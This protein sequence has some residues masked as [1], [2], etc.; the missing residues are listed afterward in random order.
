M[1]ILHVCHLDGSEHRLEFETGLSVREVL[2]G[3][4]YRV[5]A[6]CGGTG[7]C[8]ACQVRWLAGEA[9]PPGLAEYQKLTP[10]ERAAGER[11]ACQLRPRG[12]VRILLDHPAPPSRW[13]SIDPADLRPAPGTRPELSQHVY[14]VAV[15]LGTIH[16]RVALW[17]RKR[18]RRIASRRGPNPQMSFGADVLN[19]LEAARDRPGRAEELARLARTAIIQAVRDILKR[20]VGE[21]TPMLAEIG[22]VVVVGNTAMLA[23]LGGRGIAELLAPEHWQSR[24][25]VRPREPEPWHRD[26]FMPNAEIILAPP[27][28]G[29]I[30]SDLAADLIACALT[31]EPAPAM[32]ID[33]GTNSEIALWD[34]E[35]LRLT[36][37]PGGPAFEGVGIRHGMPAEDGAIHRVHAG[38]DG[39]FRLDTLAGEAA[40]GYCGSGLADAI[41]VLLAA[42]RIKPSGRFAS[43][44]GPDGLRLDP[45]NPRTALTA[46]D[47]DAFL[48]AKAS[49][50][51]AMATLLAEAGLDWSDLARLVVCGAFG[52]QLDLDHARATGL[53]PALDPARIELLADA[54]L[55]GCE[56]ALLSADG[57]EYF[58][59]IASKSDTINL[60]WIEGFEDRYIDHLRL[61][62]VPPLR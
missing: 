19:R 62:P 23:L 5:R 35:R 47:V 57:I 21:V 33:V 52:R 40:R 36:S 39:G 8:G 46:A 43:S 50:S 10:E 61:R 9:N 13:R 22:Q 45:D 34:G 37:A 38:P 30:G 2:D 4:P 54:S 44:P 16:I 11:L 60:S 51:A 17:D 49:L 58:D 25:E 6:A 29:F 55:A 41:A 32:L 20:D 28:A 15:D 31:D 27:V 53:L 14:G 3:T 12:D 42:G 24:I 7:A 1:P 56:R 26:W 18:G 48:R 59:R